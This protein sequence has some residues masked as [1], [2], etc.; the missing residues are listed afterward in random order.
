VR[1]VVED[2]DGTTSI[3]TPSEWSSLPSREGWGGSS[4]SVMG[5]EVNNSYRGIVIRNGKKYIRK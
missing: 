3:I 2:E 5:T 4:Y 1:I